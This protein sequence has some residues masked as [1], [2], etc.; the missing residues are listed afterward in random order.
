MEVKE[1]ETFIVIGA[2]RTGKGTL[3]SALHGANIKYFVKNKKNQALLDSAVTKTV[4]GS[5]FLAPVGD[6]GLPIENAIIS[7][8][9]NSHTLGPKFVNGTPNYPENFNA[10]QGIH[11]IDYPGLFESKGPE[12]DISM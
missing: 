9:H 6:D 1:K 8:Q 7:H 11:S 3:L 5:T 10:L 4:V 2:S 12:L